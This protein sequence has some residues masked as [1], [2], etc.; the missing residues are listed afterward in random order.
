MH[1][2]VAH[3]KGQKKAIENGFGQAE[4]FMLGGF[5]EVEHF[6]NEKMELLKE[7][8]AE[9]KGRA[10]NQNFVAQGLDPIFENPE[11]TEAYQ[12]DKKYLA[13]MIKLQEKV[14]KC[15]NG[16]WNRQI[17]SVADKVY[18][19]D[20]L[21]NFYKENMSILE[22][23]PSLGGTSKIAKKFLKNIEA[24]R[25]DLIKAH[26]MES[27]NQKAKQLLMEDDNT[28]INNDN[29]IINNDNNIINNEPGI[30]DKINA[31]RNRR[32]LSFVEAKELMV[33]K[34]K[35]DFFEQRP[36]L[37]KE[38]QDPTRDKY[39][40]FNREVM[41]LSNSVLNNEAMKQGG[42]HFINGNVLAEILNNNML[43]DKL[44]Q[45]ESN[46]D[47][48]V[49]NNN[50][51]YFVAVNNTWTNPEYNK[52]KKLI[53]KMDKKPEKYA[54]QEKPDLDKIPRYVT[55][56]VNEGLKDAMK[57]MN[58]SWWLVTS[59]TN[60]EDV[61][62]MLGDI[63]KMKEKFDKEIIEKKKAGEPP[64]LDPKKFRKFNKTMNQCLS[65]MNHYIKGHEN[66]G[67]IRKGFTGG[68]RLE[69][70][71]ET[72]EAL[73]KLHNRTEAYGNTAP[74]PDDVK[75]AI[76]AY[77]VDDVFEKL[78]VEKN[79]NR[80]SN[81]NNKQNNNNNKQNFNDKVK[82]FESN[83]NIINTNSNNKKTNNSGFHI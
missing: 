53:E 29:N 69:A 24:M 46:V 3:L 58:K 54:K 34:I 77:K 32:D 83:N 50:V 62:G 56:T 23:N 44:A 70:V 4:L 18:V 41:R 13:D 67:W 27:G 12:K 75:N 71:L 65:A 10:Q 39:D 74:S 17:G 14:Q 33:E 82:I 30:E 72:R 26:V 68:Q 31:A 76:K 22:D 6:V 20:S 15:K 52:A 38:F 21:I 36:E 37:K 78:G 2:A 43:N 11:E 25:G 81:I 8:M 64:V 9:M 63:I 61:R 66:R 42:S 40:F 5:S 45:I 79:N 73:Y 47:V 19:A 28:V 55:K 60:F 49:R 35:Q 57:S 16:I 7:K 80:Q 51:N 59:T 1:P 48:K